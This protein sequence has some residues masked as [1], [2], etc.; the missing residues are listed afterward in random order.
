VARL[1]IRSLF[2]ALRLSGIVL[3][4]KKLSHPRTCL[5]LTQYEW[6]DDVDCRDAHTIIYEEGKPVAFI[7]CDPGEIIMEVM[8][9]DPVVNEREVREWIRRKYDV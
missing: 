2:R 3:T 8:S 6:G 4:T 1:S 5:S 7:N 9:F